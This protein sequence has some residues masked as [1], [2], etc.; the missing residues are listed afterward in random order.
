M[1]CLSQCLK[2]INHWIVF[3][4]HDLELVWKG[5]PRAAVPNLSIWTG[6]SMYHRLLKSKF[7]H[8]EQWKLARTTIWFQSTYLCLTKMTETFS[9]KLSVVIVTSRKEQN[10]LTLLS[11]FHTT[12]SINNYC[13]ATFTFEKQ[14][15][16][17]KAKPQHEKNNRTLTVKKGFFLFC[18]FWSGL[19]CDSWCD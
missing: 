5:C 18:L 16:L 10:N 19:T 11:G 8:H 9:K 17:C 4:H 15:L 12:F 3:S 2:Y 1:I 13:A 14:E 6:P 7:S